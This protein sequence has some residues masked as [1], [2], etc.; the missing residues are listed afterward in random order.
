MATDPYRKFVRLTE[1]LWRVP[2]PAPGKAPRRAPAAPGAPVALL[3]SPH[4]DD[5]V[6]TGLLPLRLQRE[7]GARVVNVA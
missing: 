6:L 5:E 4:P 2:L 7:A 3:F 1:Q